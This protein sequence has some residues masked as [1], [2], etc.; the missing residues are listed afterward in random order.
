MFTNGNLKSNI[1]I[2]DTIFEGLTYLFLYTCLLLLLWVVYANTGAVS[3]IGVI[4]V[5]MY[6]L[7]CVLIWRIDKIILI[8]LTPFLLMQ[9]SSLISNSYLEYG[10][11]VSE[12]KEFTY[13]TG[14]TLR[15]LTLQSVFFISAV[16]AFQFFNS[17][18]LLVSI[19]NEKKEIAFEDYPIIFIIILMLLILLFNIFI[20][21]APII[22]KVTR[23]DYWSSIHGGT[24]LKKIL[25]LLDY[26]SFFIGVL[27]AKYRNVN[28]LRKAL[29]LGLLFSALLLNILYGEKF[30]GIF[31]LCMMYLM[32]YLLVQ[33]IKGLLDVNPVKILLLVSTMGYLFYILISWSYINLYY[34]SEDAVVEIIIHRIFELQGEVWWVVD[35][36]VNNGLTKG[37]ALD[38]IKHNS[39]NK[40]GGIFLLMELIAPQNTFDEYV[41]K[42]VPF[43]MGYPAIAVYTLGYVGAFILQIISGIISAIVAAYAMRKAI[44]SQYIRG[45]AAIILYL[46]CMWSFN[47]GSVYV[48]FSITSGLAMFILILDMLVLKEKKIH[49]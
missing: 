13:A 24:I 39:E 17:K 48:L 26:F 40:P 41:A 33:E 27:Y 8:L 19:S 16:A 15:L 43:T 29:I 3:V 10:G 37:V 42:G 32:G 31:L 49:I 34:Y 9:F 35:N 18:K 28:Y 23:F 38:L 21:G 4:S 45:S 46:L 30:S 20:Q 14:S 25:A 44:L 22:D 47:L 5:L 11:Y 12:A 6:L 2:P 7:L 36:N 1:E